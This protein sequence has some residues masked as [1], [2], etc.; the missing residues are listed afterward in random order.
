MSSGTPTQLRDLTTLVARKR[1]ELE[2]VSRKKALLE[3]QLADLHQ[4]IEHLTARSGAAGPGQGA[5]F[6]GVRRRQ[7]RGLPE[8]VVAVEAGDS[9][10]VRE[11]LRA[12][13]SP[14]G[15]NKDGEPLLLLAVSRPN[16]VAVVRELLKAGAEVDLRDRS[17]NTALISCVRDEELSAVKELVLA[18]ADLNAR[19]DDGDTPLTN[20]ACWGSAKVVRLLLASGADPD[21]RDGAGLSAMQLAQQQGHRAVGEILRRAAEIY[22]PSRSRGSPGGKLAL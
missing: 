2:H 21:V 17:G 14:N 20:A 8:L 10:L 15:R 7:A 5:S 12:G 6:S 9:Q 22:R 19:N 4:E 1:A 13:A 18:G 3:R 11:S 16:N